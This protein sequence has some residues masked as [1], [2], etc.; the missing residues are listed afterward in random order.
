MTES[1]ALA[2]HD[3]DRRAHRCA[4]RER[5][6]RRRRSFGPSPSRRGGRRADQRGVVPGELGERLAAAPA[7]SRCWRSGRRHSADRAGRRA[8]ARAGRASPPRA[9]A[10]LAV[11]HA[12]ATARSAASRVRRRRRRA[13]PS[14]STPR[15]R[16]ARSC[17]LPVRAHDVVARLSRRLAEHGASSSCAAAP[18]YSGAISGWMMRAVPS[19]ARTSLQDSR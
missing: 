7:A 15:S 10:R 5:R 9:S 6:A 19:K 17:C 13:A 16:R 3:P 8:P 18:A 12:A 2:G 11:R 1:S 14:A 4:R